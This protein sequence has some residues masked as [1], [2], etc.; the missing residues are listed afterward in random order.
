MGKRVDIKADFK[1][2]RVS[3][4]ESMVEARRS[5]LLLLLDWFEEE[6][7]KDKGCSD[8]LRPQDETQNEKTMYPP[9]GEENPP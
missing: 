7:R 8:V 9:T 5:A 1:I 2:V 3:L 6:R 4:P